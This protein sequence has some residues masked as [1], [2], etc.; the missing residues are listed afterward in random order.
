[1]I[2]NKDLFFKAI[3]LRKANKSYTTIHALTGL[4][5]ST[6]S[7]WFSKKDWSKHIAIRLNNDNKVLNARRLLLM[8]TAKH[9]KTKVRHEGYREQAKKEYNQLRTDPLFVAGLSIYWGE[10]DKADNGRVSVINTDTAMLQLVVRFYR[11]IFK[12]SEKKLRAG[13]FL[14]KDL[15]EQRMLNHWSSALKISKRQFVKTQ[16]LTSRS[17]LTKRKSKFGICSVYFSDTKIQVIMYEWI[18]LFSEEMRV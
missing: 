11:E 4:S 12:I 7:S 5:K 3:T 2:R 6:L 14:Y 16:I 8:N 9:Q 17:I 13:M 15:N 10:G 18:R 1:M